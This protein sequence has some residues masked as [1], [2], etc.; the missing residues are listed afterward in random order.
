MGDTLLVH[1]PGQSV[2][3]AIRENIWTVLQTIQEAAVI[4]PCQCPYSSPVILFKKKDRGVCFC[5]VYQKVIDITK[6]T[7]FWYQESERL[8]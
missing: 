4:Q 2:N 1:V 3:L 8:S 7:P 5:I 6:V